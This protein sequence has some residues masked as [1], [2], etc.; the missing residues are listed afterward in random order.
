[1]PRR[2]YADSGIFIA[3]LNGNEQYSA[4]C[5]DILQAAESGVVELHTSFVSVTEV[6]KRRTESLRR[7]AEDE[8][9]ISD[10][11]DEPF[12]HYSALEISVASYA[13]YVVWD[14]HAQVRDAIH[15]ATAIRRMC[16]L[17]YTT[18]S[19]LLPRSGFANG[20][21]QLPEIRLPEFIRDPQLPL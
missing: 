15:L 14:T 13:R 11:M 20:R 18:D 8:R 6:L 19:R 17:F 9:T 7:G 10:F 12:I 21:I 1:M 4:E 16:D 2:I 3:H 5:A